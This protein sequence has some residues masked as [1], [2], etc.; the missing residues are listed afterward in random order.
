MPTFTS[1][2]YPANT[3]TYL[4]SQEQVLI[5]SFEDHMQR[6][7]PKKAFT[8][9]T[10][11][12]YCGKTVLKARIGKHLSQCTRAT[13]CPTC[14]A[15]LSPEEYTDHSQAC[16]YSQFS[17]SRPTPVVQIHYSSSEDEDKAGP[18]DLER[19]LPQLNMQNSDSYGPEH[20][21]VNI[22]LGNA[23]T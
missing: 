23:A 14:L 10:E 21:E 5:E 17:L 18:E 2:Q 1:L 3:G 8:S 9:R 6:C 13:Q 11:C 12:Y 7:R 15:Y 16:A 20:Y 4:H 19:Q 22:Y